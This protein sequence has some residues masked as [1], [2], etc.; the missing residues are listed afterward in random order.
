M[1]SVELLHPDLPGL[2]DA[3]LAMR[4]KSWQQLERGELK[5]G[6]DPLTW[7]SG[8]W[9]HGDDGARSGECECAVGSGKPRCWVQGDVGWDAERGTRD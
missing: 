3:Y 6:D 5:L 4:K 2:I 7:H 8:K 1:H 9:L